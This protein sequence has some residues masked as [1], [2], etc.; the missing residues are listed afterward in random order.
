MLNAL[1]SLLG[2]IARGV[3]FGS[4]YRPNLRAN[5]NLYQ[6]SPQTSSHELSVAVRLRAA[7]LRSLLI[8]FSAFGII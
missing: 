6:L 8:L 3:S 4:F 5:A 2:A 7:D 1:I